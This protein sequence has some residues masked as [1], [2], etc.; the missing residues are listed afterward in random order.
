[1]AKRQK[2][3]KDLTLK[4][5]TDLETHEVVI[6]SGMATFVQVGKALAA[7]R[8]KR[9]YRTLAKPKR[10]FSDYCRERWDMTRDYAYKLI[11]SS[12]A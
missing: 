6:E 2:Q 9:L 5:Q 12:G 11:E 8:D 10:T 3:V 4:E 7:I 1:M